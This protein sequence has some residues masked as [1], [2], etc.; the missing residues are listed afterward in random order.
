MRV[1][2]WLLTKNK[3]A[4]GSI[5]RAPSPG[6]MAATFITRSSSRTAFSG[7][8][9]GGNGDAQ[10]VTGQPF[11]FSLEPAAPDESARPPPLLA[12]AGRSLR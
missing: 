10:R 9:S 5:H 3:K 7:S 2:A 6:G 1:V 12:N 4:S 8:R 11:G